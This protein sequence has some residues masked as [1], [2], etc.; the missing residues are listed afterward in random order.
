MEE[1][2]ELAVVSG[3][4]SL[5]E[6]DS[7]DVSLAEDNSRLRI[8]EFSVIPILEK[9]LGDYRF[10]SVSLFACFIFVEFGDNT[11]KENANVAFITSHLWIGLLMASFCAGMLYFR[12]SKLLSDA[13]TEKGLLQTTKELSGFFVRGT[14]GYKRLQDLNKQT[15][16]GWPESVL[17]FMML[18][19]VVSSAIAFLF[20]MFAG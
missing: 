5:T 7:D 10:L 9:K 13:V 4:N 20:L 19:G 18:A 8:L 12:T 16:G 14:V 6:S 1:T 2:W 11:L 3:E 17:N 15:L